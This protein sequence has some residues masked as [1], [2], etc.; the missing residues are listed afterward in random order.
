MWAR[1]PLSESSRLRQV[2][3]NAGNRCYTHIPIALTCVPDDASVK[4][5]RTFM[6]TTF[7][8]NSAGRMLDMCMEAL[9]LCNTAT[10]QK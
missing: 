10:P 7:A 2:Q 9:S 4:R 6:A 5:L 3:K 1:G 8:G